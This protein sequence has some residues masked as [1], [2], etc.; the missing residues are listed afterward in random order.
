M[1]KLQSGIYP[2]EK[3]LMGKAMQHHT[4]PGQTAYADLKRL[5]LDDMAGDLQGSIRRKVINGKNYLYESFRVGARMKD[6]YIGEATPELEAR[7]AIKQEIKAAAAERQVSRTR[8]ARTLR[9]EGYIPLDAKTGSILTALAR[10][11]VFRLG[12]T[13]VGTIAFRLYEGELGVR[14]GADKLAQTGDIDIASFERLSVALGDHVIEPLGEVFGALSFEAVPSLN[15]E[16]VWRW[17]DT[18]SEV[19]VEFLTAAFGDEDIRPLPSLG[20]S[21]Q[22]LN[23]LNFLLADPIK[24]VALYRSGVLVQIPRPEAYAIHK[25]IVADRRKKGPDAIKALKDR[26]QAAFLIEVLAQDRPDELAEAY[27]D[28]LS[29]GPKW[30]ARIAA[31][32]QRMPDSR[33]L[34]EAL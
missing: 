25:L 9:A 28:A 11:G 20:V 23:Y 19:M 34:L 32:L 22:A 4:L 31:T 26:A 5:L 7:V 21:A 17:A 12:G 1:G 13:L 3:S 14:I 16:H 33:A 29:R 24:A 2:S 30:Q 27:Q 10:V 8:L 15:K 6:R 18:K